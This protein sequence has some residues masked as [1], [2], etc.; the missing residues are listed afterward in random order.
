MLD[1]RR[2]DLLTGVHRLS[3]LAELA[4]QPEHVPVMIRNVAAWASVAPRT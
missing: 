2:I 4:D 1:R 3:E